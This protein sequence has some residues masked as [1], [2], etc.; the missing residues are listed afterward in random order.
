MGDRRIP[1]RSGRLH[2]EA[3]R[4]STPKP[5]EGERTCYDWDHMRNATVPVVTER[6]ETEELPEEE[7]EGDA[8]RADEEQE[9]TEV[10]VN[11]FVSD[12]ERE[13]GA[14]TGEEEEEESE[15]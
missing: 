3:T 14:A 8:C 10:E 15:E 7:G 13:E 11:G 12:I 2:G 9:R 1:L 6:Q 5:A 4:H